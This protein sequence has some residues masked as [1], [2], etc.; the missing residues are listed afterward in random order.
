MISAS[1]CETSYLKDFEVVRVNV[2]CKPEIEQVTPSVPPFAGLDV[3]REPPLAFQRFPLRRLGRSCAANGETGPLLA[4]QENV[5]RSVGDL[6]HRDLVDHW[7]L[8]QRGRRVRGA[9]ERYAA[10]EDRAPDRGRLPEET[11]AVKRSVHRRTPTLGAFSSRF[12]LR[13]IGAPVHGSVY[14][15]GSQHLLDH[16]SRGSPLVRAGGGA[17]FRQPISPIG[18]AGR[19][20]PGRAETTRSL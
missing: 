5:M 8:D 6:T 12:E 2:R 4:T 10:C 19:G 11:A 13:P 18:P 7:R 14:L 15:F 9:I 3:E 20:H 17:R 16:S 1:T